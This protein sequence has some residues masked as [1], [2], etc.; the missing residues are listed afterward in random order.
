MWKTF[1][2]TRN[3]RI[4]IEYGKPHRFIKYIDVSI[5]WTRQV[6]YAGFRFLISLLGL[7][8]FVI[9]IYDIR[10]WNDEKK[11]WEFRSNNKW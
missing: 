5:C 9:E 7:F 11:C 2:L 3:K 6:D 8:Y 4:D 1:P 10:N